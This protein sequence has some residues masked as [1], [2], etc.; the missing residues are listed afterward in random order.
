MSSDSSINDL[1]KEWLDNLR[2]IV[3]YSKHTLVA[4]EQDLDNF[5]LFLKNNN[6]VVDIASFQESDLKQFRRWLIDRK[7]VDYNISSTARA[8]SGIKSFYSFLEKFYEVKNEAIK[9]LKAPKLSRNLPKALSEED[10]IMLIEKSD[11]FAKHDWLSLR[12]K[13]LFILLYSTAIRISEAINITKE[14]LKEND[15]IIYGKGS[16]ERIVPLM[17]K[18]RNLIYDY[19]S[20]LPF[21]LDANM[22]IFRGE[23]GK[24]L[25]AGVVQS[26]LR[27]LRRTLG[28]PEHVTPH[29]FRHSCATHLLNNNGNLRSIQTLLGHENINTTQKYTHIS[30]THLLNSYQKFHPLGDD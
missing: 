10:I 20:M 26:N 5:I 17:P 13:A 4:Y 2:H 16:K 12:D 11:V 28:L 27:K 21:E 8:I 24:T 18:V 7:M 15:I 29:S 19:L 9:H 1:K 3:K 30:H 22:P 6:I 23:R 25:Q 14:S